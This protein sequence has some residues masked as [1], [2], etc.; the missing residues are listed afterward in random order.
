MQRRC[1]QKRGR[2]VQLH[3]VALARLRRS[4]SV[5]SVRSNGTTVQ[6]LML[7][8]TVALFFGAV[9]PRPPEVLS[10]HQSLAFSFATRASPQARWI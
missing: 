5:A 7:Q 8:I 9:C 10:M 2:N 3:A 1:K 6:F 4:T